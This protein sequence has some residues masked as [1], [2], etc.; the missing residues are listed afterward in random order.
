MM[1]EERY[2][3]GDLI[4]GDRPNVFFKQQLDLLPPGR[5]LL[6]ADGQGRNGIYA[7][8]KGWEVVCF[9]ISQSARQK[10]LE[11]AVLKKLT[12]DYILS[13]WEEI[14]LQDESFDAIAL[15]YAHTPDDKRRIFHRKMAGLLKQGGTILL[16]AFSKEQLKFASGGPGN[17]NMLYSVE[18]IQQD[19]NM[20]RKISVEKVTITLEEGRLHKGDASVIRLCGKK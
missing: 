15:I 6:P 7:A 3:G 4:Y 10:A 18:D 19:F 16:E 14:V 1:W 11:L 17:E 5:I 12:I 2:A 9:D 13:G 8:G 20:L